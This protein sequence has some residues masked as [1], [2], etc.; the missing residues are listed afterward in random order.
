M[1]ATYPV[2]SGRIAITSAN[3][4]IK[5]SEDGSALTC[6]LTAGTYFLRNSSTTTDADNFLYHLKTQL[7]ATGANTYTITI[8]LSIS[9]GSP[10]A[11]IT[12]TRASGSVT[13]ALL[14]ANAATTFD[15][16]ILG[17]AASDTADDANAKAST[18][19]PSC[20][21]VGPDVLEQSDPD[22][23]NDATIS[24]A[25]GGQVRGF[26]R[27][28]PYDVR[29]LSFAFID[30]KRAIASAIAADPDRAWSEWWSLHSD[31]RRFEYHEAAISSGSTLAALS[32]STKVGT[33]WHLDEDSVKAMRPRR[34]Q[35]GLELYGW[36]AR[37]LGY[38]A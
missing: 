29:D 7:E 16:A 11:T 35:P 20:L 37:L 36:P 13:F 38:V 27:G 5:F 4:V 9:A 24:R 32:A 18:L 33:A 1:T 2:F 15:P 23:E 26:K 30:P 25:M 12:V 28:G 17:F 21:W 22:Y 8:A 10:S 6:T 19:S 3:N 31:G 34:L 14:F